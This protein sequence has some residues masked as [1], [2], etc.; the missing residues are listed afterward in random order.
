MKQTRIGVGTFIVR[1]DA[2]VDL[3]KTLRRLAHIGYEGVEL[4]GFFGKTAKEVHY[5]LGKTGIP[6]FGDHVSLADFLRDSERLID[7]H[8]G[9]GCGSVTLGICE[10]DIIS[11]PFDQLTEHYAISAERCL[12]HGIV[13]LYHNHAFDMHEDEPFAERILDAVTDLCFEPDLGWM[14][15]AG[16]DPG[17]YLKKY[18]TRIP[19]VHLKDVSMT[20]DGFGFRPTGYGVA[21]TPAL[22]PAILAC[23]PDWLMVDHDLAYDRDPYDDLRLSYEY[24][25]ELLW[26]AG[27]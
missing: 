19:V 21:N 12:Q 2:A 27:E 25:K 1:D 26:V 14:I 7:D 18:Q 10:A 23:E 8:L 6:V 5:A 9:I 17:T 3:E 11:H 15:V 16:K 13:P 4:L 20:E 24:V 22:L